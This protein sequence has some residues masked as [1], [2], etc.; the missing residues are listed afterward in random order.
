[1]SYFPFN[2]LKKEVIN[3]IKKDEFLKEVNKIYIH[4]DHLK[5]GNYII[6]IM[7]NKKAVKT[8][9]ISKS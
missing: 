2:L 9:K 3:V 6:N 7:Q 5:N 8:I 4:I 1:M